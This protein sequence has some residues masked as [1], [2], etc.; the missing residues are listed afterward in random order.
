MRSKESYL[1]F[2]VFLAKRKITD[3]DRRQDAQDRS[4]VEML[5]IVEDKGDVVA[6]E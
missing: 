1:S 6:D 3:E 5:C 4:K 2:A